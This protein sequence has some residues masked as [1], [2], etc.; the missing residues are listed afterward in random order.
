MIGKTIEQQLLLEVQS[1]LQSS[2]LATIAWGGYL[3]AQHRV[4]TAV[5]MLQ[6]A[7]HDLPQGE[8]RSYAA[9]A[10]MD[11]LVVHGANV[12]ADD[13]SDFR[14][15]LTEGAALALAANDP[16]A[17]RA[18]LLRMHE[19]TARG[20][21]SRWLASGNL[22]AQAKDRDFARSAVAHL[23]YQLTVSVCEESNRMG[24]GMAGAIGGK[25]GDGKF[26][27]PM[28]FPPAVTYRIVTRP[29]AG[30]VLFAAGKRHAYFRREIHHERAVRDGSGELMQLRG[31]Q[32]LH[33]DWLGTM[34][35]T[36]FGR[37]P[38][39]F[40]E[41]IYW[42]TAE[43]CLAEVEKLRAAIAQRHDHLVD[44]AIKAGWFTEDERA[45]LAAKVAVKLA[46]RRATK[47]PALPRL[48]SATKKSAIKKSASVVRYMV[49]SLLARNEVTAST[50]SCATSR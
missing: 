42:S 46:D 29:K 3:S 38:P 2:D 33:V 50:K 7:L 49:E 5:P 20:R 6:Q 11:A 15:G 31:R 14:S 39:Q 47:K 16:V 41:R 18:F 21:F 43:H 35:G 27:T 40:S 10:L 36:A 44:R 9:Q 23:S 19:A 45:G 13:L 8:H 24:G 34:L 17:H 4:A 37:L 26:V 1:R 22:L 25:F 48:K 12:K 30:D 28:G 32:Q